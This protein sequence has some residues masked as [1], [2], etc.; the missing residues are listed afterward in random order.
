VTDPSGPTR[1]AT[2][3]RYDAAGGSPTSAVNAVY[4]A[5]ALTDDRS[6]AEPAADDGESAE[7]APVRETAKR[8]RSRRRGRS[9]WQRR[10][11]RLTFFA[12]SLAGV[13]A[14]AVWALFGSRLLVVRSV[15]IT[16]TKLV[17]RSEVLAA[18]GVEPGRPL[19]EVNA[20]QV[21][22]R[23]DA[24]RQVR[25][26]QVTRSWPGR[27]VIVVQERTPAVAVT[28]PGG[29]W[30]MV[31]ADGVIVRWA[32]SHPASLPVYTATVPVTSLRGDP[33]LSAAAAVLAGLPA[34]LK[35][36]V[37]SVTA[38]SPDQV[39]FQLSGG[40]TVVWGGADRT[41][42]K[43]Q[44]LTALERTGSHYYDVSAAGVLVTK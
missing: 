36:S 34:Q 44:E 6:S 13:A 8:P 38:P 33:D 43:A 21:A 14:L 35:G 23:I 30:D 27:L 1:E 31:D 24:I 4:D 32:T 22:S 15:V 25:S 41:V 40:I 17:P 7:S 3:S 37:E 26:A 5:R 9:A 18:A 39:T 28:A 11:W 42:A 2:A 29:G 12:L 10:S 20:R 19:I 16:G